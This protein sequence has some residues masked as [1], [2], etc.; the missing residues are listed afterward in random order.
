MG[1]LRRVILRN[2]L[3]IFRTATTD[4]YVYSRD[5]EFTCRRYFIDFDFY[6]PLIFRDEVHN[7]G[8]IEKY[9]NNMTRK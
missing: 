3:S 1:G 4:G 2:N 6:Y 9:W 5:F 7:G 8:Y